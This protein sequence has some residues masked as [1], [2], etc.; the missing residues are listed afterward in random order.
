MSAFR[1]P[2]Q[3]ALELRRRQLEREEARHKLRVAEV[4]ALDRARAEAE[5]ARTSAGRQ[6]RD[7]KP[8]TGEDLAALDRFRLHMQSE[9]VR[10]AERRKETARL[11]AEQEATM[12]DARRRCRLLEKLRERRLAEWQA[13]QDRELDERAAES[14]LAGWNRRRDDPT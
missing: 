7:W 6:V 8:L 4:A 13:A 12:L 3:K 9:G 14:F 10:I 1:F 11:A 5:S 2:L